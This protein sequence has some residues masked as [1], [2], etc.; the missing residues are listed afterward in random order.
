MTWPYHIPLYLFHCAQYLLS[1]RC[2]ITRDR[3]VMNSQLLTW[4]NSILLYLHHS[5]LVF[6]RDSCCSLFCFLC[7]CLCLFACDDVRHVLCF[8][9]LRSV[10][11]VMSVSLDC[12]FLIARSVFSIVYLVAFKFYVHILCNYN[13]ISI[14]NNCIL[15]T[16][17]IIQ[18]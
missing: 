1:I 10:C 5:S 12:P 15:G 9:F 13:D 8:V 4:R 7:N 14:I 11:P 16:V 18:E 6:N 17:L 2:H 3:N